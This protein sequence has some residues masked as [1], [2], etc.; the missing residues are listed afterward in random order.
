MPK[1]KKRVQTRVVPLYGVDHTVQ[2]HP[3]GD[4][5]TVFTSIKVGG[6]E[7]LDLYRWQY[8]LTP[9]GAVPLLTMLSDMMESSNVH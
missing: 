9:V 5:A 3:A 1:G 2:W 4:G 7:V 6:V 8:V